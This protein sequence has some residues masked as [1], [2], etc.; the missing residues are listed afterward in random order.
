[1][2]VSQRQYAR[3]TSVRFECDGGRETG[4]LVGSENEVQ[5]CRAA[6]V[7]RCRGSGGW[8]ADNPGVYIVQC[9]KQQGVRRGSCVLWRARHRDSGVVE[10]V[11]VIVTQTV[12]VVTVGVDVAVV[13][14]VGVVI[15]VTSCV[16]VVMKNLLTNKIRPVGPVKRQENY[17]KWP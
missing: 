16:E 17:T 13:T 12:G 11:D 4:W 7:Q 10:M 9:S 2:R 1:M 14:T 3:F 8:V 15:V 5:R 6:E